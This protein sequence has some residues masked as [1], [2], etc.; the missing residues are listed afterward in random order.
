MGGGTIIS[1]TIAGIRIT[2]TT[3]AAATAAGDGGAGASQLA[4]PAA[5]LPRSHSRSQKDR[6]SVV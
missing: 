5:A 4:E 6:K 2:T 1:E 3:A